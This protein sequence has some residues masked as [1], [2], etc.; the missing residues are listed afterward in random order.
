MVFY[1]SFTCYE[2]LIK[3]KMSETILNIKAE[4][5]FWKQDS[6]IIFFNLAIH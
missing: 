2:N 4:S 1:L 6:W 5:D 3:S